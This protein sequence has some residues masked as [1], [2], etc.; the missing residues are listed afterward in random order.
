MAQLYMILPQVCPHTTSTRNPRRAR[1]SATHWRRKRVV[2]NPAPAWRRPKWC[3]IVALLAH[4][5]RQLPTR[6][7]EAIWCRRNV[8]S[9][10]QVA[11]SDV[12][13]KRGVTGPR[14]VRELGAIVKCGVKMWRHWRAKAWRHLIR[15]LQGGR[16]RCW[17]CTTVHAN[18][19]AWRHR[20]WRQNVAMWHQ[21]ARGIG[22]RGGR[23]WRQAPSTYTWLRWTWLQCVASGGPGLPARVFKM[24]LQSSGDMC[25]PTGDAPENIF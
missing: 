18:G 17:S 13:S 16:W 22:G 1:Q 15:W 6:R 25:T 3:R 11:S 20:T 2:A 24:C 14:S 4:M 7:Q 19:L 8:A 23:T 9:G 5:R 21:T 12:A 10:S